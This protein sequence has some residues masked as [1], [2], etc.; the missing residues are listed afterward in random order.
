MM[1]SKLQSIESNQT[2]E[3]LNQLAVILRQSYN[4]FN[5]YGKTPEQMTD[6]IMAFDMV[7]EPF[8]GQEVIGAFSWWLANKS[9]MPTPADIRKYIVDEKNKERASFND[10]IRGKTWSDLTDEE[11]TT[12]GKLAKI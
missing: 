1:Q 11:K 5:L 9:S 10:K 2:D 7:L 12:L 8:S 6:V 3:K 4:V